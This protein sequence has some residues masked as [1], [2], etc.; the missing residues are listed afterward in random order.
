ML[1]GTPRCLLATDTTIFGSLPPP[2]NVVIAG[3]SPM[4]LYTLSISLFRGWLVRFPIF[5]IFIF[6]NDVRHIPLPLIPS[7]RTSKYIC[8]VAK[9]LAKPCGVYGSWILLILFSYTKTYI[10]VVWL[11]ALKVVRALQTSRKLRLTILPLLSLLQ[12]IILYFFAF[13]FCCII[14]FNFC[15]FLRTYCEYYRSIVT[16]RLY[17]SAQAGEY[18]SIKPLG[19]IRVHP[20]LVLSIILFV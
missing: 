4:L 5:T 14:T 13:L 2:L 8:L 10:A 15:H 7:K 17:C 12:L 3:A 9:S 11:L 6:H 19:T 20:S 18:S 1:G 16:I